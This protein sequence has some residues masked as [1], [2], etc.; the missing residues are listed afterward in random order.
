M[1]TLTIPSPL[2][3]F[4]RVHDTLYQRT[5]GWV[6]HRIPGMPSNLML[7]TVGAKTGA[8][9]TTT[10]TYANDGNDYLIVASNGGATRNPA[11]YHNIKAHPAVEINIGPR[12]FP[13]TAE[14]VGPD[15]PDYERLWRVVNDNN[16]DRYRAYQKKTTRPISVIRLRP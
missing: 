5:R 12:R 14:I 10:L 2:V 9:R 7:H 6:G 1:P 16:S 13:V 11:W 4:V 8:P 15:H 3:A